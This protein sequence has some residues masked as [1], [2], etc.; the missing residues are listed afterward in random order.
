M[1]TPINDFDIFTMKSSLEPLTMMPSQG[2]ISQS[3]DSMDSPLPTRKWI[4]K[5]ASPGP[6]PVYLL[7]IMVKPPHALFF[8]VHDD[9]H[10]INTYGV[11]LQDFKPLWV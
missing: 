7:S 2:P 6:L 10:S 9:D 4:F 5:M 3:S 11:V 1:Q 8:L